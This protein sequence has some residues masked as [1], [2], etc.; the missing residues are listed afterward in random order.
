MTLASYDDLQDTG[1]KWLGEVPA[2][3]NVGR[4]R[5]HFRESPEKIDKEVVGVMLSVSG[6]RGIEIKEYDDENRRR[7]DE[8]LVGYRIVRVGQLVVNSMWLNAAGLG[9]SA[10]EGHVSPAYRCYWIGDG[11]NLRYVHHLM[12]SAVYVDA[13]TCMAQ[14]IRPNSLQLS[15][16]DLMNLPVLIP[17]PDRAKGDL[18]VPRCGNVEDRRFGVG[19]ASFDRVAEGKASGGHQSRGHQRPEP[20]RPHETLRHPMA[21]RCPAALEDNPLKTR[22]FPHCRLPS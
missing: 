10:F 5:H 4:F 7:L 21:R 20:E 14:G 2:H 17:P 12:R 11:I 22:N 6:Y 18:V 19:A 1:V 13:Y 3:W 15:R 8:E 16:T 9:V